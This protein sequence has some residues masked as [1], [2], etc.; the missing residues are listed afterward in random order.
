MPQHV[1]APERAEC[2][3]AGQQTGAV[4]ADLRPGLATSW[5]VDPA[6]PHRWILELR[7]GVKWHDGCDFTAADVVWNFDRVTN[8]KAPQFHPK[9]FAMIRTRTDNIE[10][11]EALDDY[12]I[13]MTTRQVDALFPYQLVF[14]PRAYPWTPRCVCASHRWLGTHQTPWRY[15]LAAGSAPVVP[16]RRTSVRG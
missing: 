16:M 7:P 8:E 2:G 9:Q 5:A 11:V 4:V 3:K 6:N 1:D 10:Q 12:K 15:R 13:V 14:W